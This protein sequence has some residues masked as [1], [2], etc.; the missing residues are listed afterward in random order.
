[1]IEKKDFLKLNK[2]IFDMIYKLTDD[3]IVEV[4]NGNMKIGILK[5]KKKAVSKDINSN[6]E[7]ASISDDIKKFETRKEAEEY[8]SKKKFTIKLLR[9]IAKYNNIYISSKCR[10]N[11]II[12]EIIEGIIGMRL[13]FNA[14]ND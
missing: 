1:M 14:L 11:E 12:D 13:K 9:Q 7:I 3:E 8:L 2:M 6:E 4:L 5:K 10:K